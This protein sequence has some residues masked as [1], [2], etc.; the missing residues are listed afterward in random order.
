[1]DNKGKL[2]EFLFEYSNL[3]ENSIQEYINRKLTRKGGEQNIGYKILS[4]LQYYKSRGK[5]NLWDDKKIGKE[6]GLSEK[7]VALQR[8]RLLKELRRF[9][10]QTS[11][12]KFHDDKTEA[13]FERYQKDFELG[14]YKESVKFFLKQGKKL[15]QEINKGKLTPVEYRKSVT[16]LFNAWDLLSTHYYNQRKKRMMMML[17]KKVQKYYKRIKRNQKQKKLTNRELLSIESNYME[18]KG[19]NLTLNLNTARKVAI[20]KNLKQ[21]LLNNY[22]KLNSASKIFRNTITLSILHRSDGDFHK[23]EIVINDAIKYAEKNGQ[24]DGL[25]LMQLLQIELDYFK[26]KISGIELY[27]RC[28]ECY[29][30]YKIGETPAYII[31]SALWRLYRSTNFIDYQTES[32]NYTKK[33]V[34]FCSLTGRS[35]EAFDRNFWTNADNMK[36]EIIQWTIES[37]SDE[38]IPTFNE[39]AFNSFVKF[40]ESYISQHFEINNMNR[41]GLIYIFNI[42]IEFWKM[43][44]ADFEKSYLMMEKLE[45]LMKKHKTTLSPVWLYFSKVFMKILDELRYS[46]GKKVYSKF[47][48]QIKDVIEIMTDKSNKF[49]IIGEYAQLYILAKNVGISELSHDAKYVYKWIKENRPELLQPII[50]SHSREKSSSK[51]LVIE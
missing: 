8:Y 50:E 5:L 33:L 38:L 35:Y 25:R 44:D 2:T 9:A 10:L 30:S 3:P 32:E 6:L 18:I 37:S 14:F 49:N 27:H 34:E 1:M 4:R 20:Y 46:D 12:E 22:Y 39:R 28:K 48:K 40:F 51:K 43:K 7:A 42:E 36:N 24:K 45:R 29:E 23:A 26:N 15:E 19:R 41:L 13:E 31:Y 21:E 16:E 47:A 11:P 17:M